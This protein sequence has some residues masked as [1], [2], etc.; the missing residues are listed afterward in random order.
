MNCSSNNIFNGPAVPTSIT[1]TAGIIAG[2][3]IVV[4]L[5][6]GVYTISEEQNTSAG[7]NVV[8]GNI[9]CGNLDVTGT[10]TTNG[11]TNDG[12]FTN[13]GNEQLNGNLNVTGSSTTNGINNTG[14]I[15]NSGEVNTNSLDVSGLSTQSGINN[16]GAINNTGPVT[17]NG[18]LTALGT[19]N[20]SGPANMGTLTTGPLSVNGAAAFAIDTTFAQNINVSGSVTSSSGI[21][22]GNLNVGGSI[23]TPTLG[24]TNDAFV[25]AQLS[26]PQTTNQIKFNN[27]STGPLTFN[28]PN[29]D[30]LTTMTLPRHVGLVTDSIIT[31][32]NS[33]STQSINGNLNIGNNL[34]VGGTLSSSTFSTG[35]ITSN[36]LTTN[37]LLVANDINPL[38]IDY[39]GTGPLTISTTDQALATNIEI[40]RY[41][42]ISNDKFLTQGD[43]FTTQVINNNLQINNILDVFGKTTTAEVDTNLVKILPSGAQLILDTN[44]SGPV[45]ISTADSTTSTSMTIPRYTGLLN[46]SFIT[47]AA[48]TSTQ[49]INGGLNV[50]GA[51]SLSDS[52]S[53]TGSVAA[54]G[55][56]SLGN[57]IIMDNTGTGP[58]TI[59]TSDNNVITNI[60]I[61]R[62]PGVSS[63]TFLTAA[64]YNGGGYARSAGIVLFQYGNI[65]ITGIQGP[66]PSPAQI[67]I[68][69]DY[70]WVYES[71]IPYL[72]SYASS[73]PALIRFDLTISFSSNSVGYFDIIPYINGVARSSHFNIPIFFGNVTPYRYTFTFF[74]NNITHPQPLNL[75]LQGVSP[76][77]PTNLNVLYITIAGTVVH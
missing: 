74:I 44:G 33:S 43:T 28:V 45:T 47:A 17:I 34:S 63:D 64:S 75:T 7:A 10:F 3:G 72:L 68:I 76:N 2:Q 19:F 13:N 11:Y 67:P 22:S 23:A 20:N 27:L 31:E 4:A 60:S 12:L 26:L 32:A 37:Q 65:T 58:L 46:D 77:F 51:V 41:S 53:V 73:T 5:N 24:V 38:V 15:N 16:T 59:S 14:N 35:N 62:V 56:V 29:N 49:N 36:N 25:A 69:V 1:P 40:P 9:D 48:P 55:N 52:L 71:G 54:S 21:I 66:L 39:T 18:N 57:N 8:F 6:S 42:T 70:P 61:P 50:G 30:V